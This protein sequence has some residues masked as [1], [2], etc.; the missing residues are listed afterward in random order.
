MVAQFLIPV[1]DVCTIDPQRISDAG[2]HL[3]GV[4]PLEEDGTV[5]VDVA[6][7][8]EDVAAGRR[9]GTMFAEHFA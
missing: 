8:S 6:L 1:R 9:M 2:G 3:L 5:R 4:G 7:P